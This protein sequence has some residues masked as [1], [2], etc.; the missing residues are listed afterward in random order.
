M[1]ET[2]GGPAEEIDVPAVLARRPRTT[3]VDD[4]EH[5]WVAGDV[6]RFRYQDV[7]AIRVAGINVI[8]TLDVQSA[9]S[10]R[11]LIAEVVEAPL[12][13]AVPESVLASA[14]EIQLVD[15]SPVALRKRLR[16]G[17]IYPAGQ[18]EPALRA[19]FDVTR[20]RGPARDRTAVRQRAR[21][22]GAPRRW[23]GTGCPGGG[24]RPP[25]R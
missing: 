7:E 13:T 16:H 21:A 18:I 11:D 8:T 3:L 5:S 25:Q 24:L 17:N 2:D 23:A 20:T 19:T 1:V 12:G 10:V 15:I 4:L 22:P 6:T 14:D 9:G